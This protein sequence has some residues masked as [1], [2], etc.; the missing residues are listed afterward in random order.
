MG[1]FER[2]KRLVIGAPRNIEDPGVYHKI[3][4]VAIL[5]WVGLGA[6]GLS[7]SAYG[8]DQAYRALGRHMSISLRAAADTPSPATSSARRWGWSPGAPS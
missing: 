3:S 1:L 6:D 8:P 2:V 4:L 7:S 5:A